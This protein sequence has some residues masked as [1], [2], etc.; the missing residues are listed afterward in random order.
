MI[1]MPFKAMTAAGLT[2]MSGWDDDHFKT[3]LLIVMRCEEC[4]DQKILK[5]TAP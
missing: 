3:T 1:E 4:G 5:E 2:K